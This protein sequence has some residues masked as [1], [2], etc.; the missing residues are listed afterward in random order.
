MKRHWWFLFLIVGLVLGC[1]RPDPVD[2]YDPDGAVNNHPDSDIPDPFRVTLV[3]PGHGPV[4]GG[5]DVTIRGFGFTENMRVAFGGRFSD[6]TQVI[7]VSPTRLLARVPAGEIGTVEVKLIENSGKEAYLGNAFTYDRFSIDPPS[8]SVTGGTFVRISSPAGELEDTDRF[9]LG[10]QELT[11]LHVVT[12][13]TATGRTPPSQPGSVTL[14]VEKIDAQNLLVADAFAYYDTTD[15][16]YGGLGG[17]PLD[18]ALTVTVLNTYGRVPVADAF[19]LLGT[20]AFSPYSGRTDENG[21]IT[22]SDPALRGRQVLTVAKEEFISTSVV[23]FDAKNATIFLEPVIPPSDPN[24]GQI[25]STPKTVYAQVAG[26]VDFKDAEFEY[27]C[28]WNRQV[29]SPAPAGYRRAVR[30]FQTLRSWN[31]AAPASYTVYDTDTC[32]DGFGIPMLFAVWPGA[33]ALVGIAGYEKDDRSDFIPVAYGVTR[34]LV[35]GPAETLNTKVVIEYQLGNR[36]N[37]SLVNAPPLVPETGPSQYRCRLFVNI[38]AD[39]Y[40]V[41]NDTVQTTDATPQFT[42]EKQMFM[43][44]PLADAQFALMADA[45]NYGQYPFSQVFLTRFEDNPV[46]VDQFLGIP[47]PLAPTSTEPVLN[48][49][50]SFT[51]SPVTQ[52]TFH[53]VKINTFPKGDAWW[54]LYVNGPISTFVLPDLSGFTGVPGKPAGWLYWHVQSVLVPDLSF[55]DFTYRYLGEKY[56]T[57]TAADGSLFTF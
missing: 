57:S 49:R 21:Q 19:V 16:A 50:F 5:T 33:F 30:V 48:D 39:G 6:P 53:I 47:R 40:V 4:E 54:R 42:Y 18:G 35:V 3:E 43:V 22:F 52:P 32:V 10:E 51:P 13:S 34:R 23:G 27:S 29:P 45:H 56:W 11:D 12:A 14:R 9:F 17:G 20:G 41:L 28:N 1:E 24:N 37:V 25:P 8:G 15:P 31:I 26:A 2:G 46:I 55:D 7:T 44:G 38:G 36:Q